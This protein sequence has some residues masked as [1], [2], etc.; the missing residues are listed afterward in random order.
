MASSSAWKIIFNGHPLPEVYYSY[1]VAKAQLR[2][3]EESAC[4]AFGR[5]VSYDDETGEIGN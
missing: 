4:G 5:I 1:D 3:M 2:C